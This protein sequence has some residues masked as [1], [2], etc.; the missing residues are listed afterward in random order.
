[1]T[2]GARWRGAVRPAALGLAAAVASL[3]GC[4]QTGPLYLP[5]D[6]STTVITRPAPA[7]TAPATTRPPATD[8]APS[9][10]AAAAS[11]ASPAPGVSDAPVK[12]PAT[13]PGKPAGR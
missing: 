7:A 10:D 5:D 13:A 9:A 1:M 12:A 8:A 2:A 3:A 11:P 6:A 4:G